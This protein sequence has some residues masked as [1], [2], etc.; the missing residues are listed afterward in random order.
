MNVLDI[1]KLKF[2]KG[3]DFFEMQK[4]LSMALFYFRLTEI[5]FQTAE[6]MRKV[7]FQNKEI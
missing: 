1:I 3:V 5:N 2:R 6:I 4:N 7:P